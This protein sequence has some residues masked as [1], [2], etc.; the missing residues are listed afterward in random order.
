MPET[1][2]TRKR[3]TGDAVRVSF[4]PVR[5]RQAA[6]CVRGLSAVFD[7][8]RRPWILPDGVDREDV[9]RVVAEGR[10]GTLPRMLAL[11]AIMAARLNDWDAGVTAADEARRLAVELGEPIWEACAE[12]GLS[13][14][15]GMRGDEEEAERAAARAEEIALPVGASFMVALTQWGRILAALG[16]A[17]YEDAYHAAARVYDP[18]D[19]AH[20][21]VFAAM[22]VGDLAE[23]ALHAGEVEAARVRVAEVEEAVGSEPAVWIAINLRHAHVLLAD[24]ETD[25]SERF[26][27]A[28]AADL[29]PW[30]FWRARLLLAYGRWLRRQ[31]RVAESRTPLRDA[32]DAFDALGCSAWGDQVRRELRA[33]GESSRRRGPM[34][35]DLL[36]AQELQIAQLAAEGLSNKE[37]AHRLYLSHRTIGTHLY[38]I[39]PKLDISSRGELAAALAPANREQW[40]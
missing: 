4:D 9:V 26:D 40:T 2:P 12:T 1:A 8:H 38:R 39:Y 16:A 32:R 37:I 25:A 7:T 20:H 33:S 6:E 34:E 11:R 22:F 27:E 14:I 24:S 23:A 28:F 15:A 30:R 31:R 17:R 29:G 13:A 18:A 35:R 5:C 3:Y 10:L 36:T 21:R 19:P